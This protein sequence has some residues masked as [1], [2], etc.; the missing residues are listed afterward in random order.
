M[1]YQEV[2]PINK[3][4]AERIFASDNLEKI[5]EALVAVSFYEE[6]WKWAQDECLK[7]LS[8]ENNIISGLAATCLGHIA[9]V[10]GK[11]E[12]G[13]VLKELNSRLNNLEI[14]GRIE[15]AMS[16]IDIFVKN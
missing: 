6:D 2:L 12:R 16:D 3:N 8:H 10:H 1:K 7:F 14:A 4:D 9:R 5:R 13:K 15:D 11:I